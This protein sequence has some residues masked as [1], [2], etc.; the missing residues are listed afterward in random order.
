MGFDKNK[1]PILPHQIRFGDVVTSTAASTALQTRGA[2]SLE[3]TST[4]GAVVYTLAAVPK[5]GDLLSIHAGLMGNTT[6]AGDFHINAGGTAAGEVSFGSS[7]EDMITFS[8]PGEGVLLIGESS[9]RWM[10]V[11]VNGAAFSTS[12]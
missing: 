1:R 3:T 2:I 10:A 12:T 5:P 8:D 6:G 11:G 9:D 7:S 4:G